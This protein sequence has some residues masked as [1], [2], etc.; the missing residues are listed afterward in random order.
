MNIDL[1][2][3][4]VLLT[5]ATRGIGEAIA[6]NLAASGAR[7]SVHF[8]RHSKRAEQLAAE[9]GNGA[10]AFQADLAHPEHCLRLFNDVLNAFG[11]ID[12][13]VNNA[14]IAYK[15]PLDE[16]DDDW[17]VDWHSTIA[18]NLTAV[19]LLCKK[20]IEHFTVMGG[21]RIINIASRASFRGDTPD[22]LAYAAS[23]GGVIPLTRSIARYFGKQGIKA[24]N[25][26]PGFVRT[27]MAQDFMNEYGEA[28]AVN[29][30]ALPELTVPED[31]APLVTFLAS[32]LCDHATGGTFDVNA[33]SYVH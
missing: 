33:G 32:G 20:A 12:V 8:L 28:F 21:G 9:L 25:V 7:V 11:H 31:L 30:I 1:T 24:F 5:G 17:L 6:K 29:D 18:V 15:S 16:D 26:A 10:K 22:Y 3:K 27:D 23:K 14:G 2:G 13:L 4:H 19:G